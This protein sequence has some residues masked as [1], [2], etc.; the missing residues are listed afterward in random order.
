MIFHP[1]ATPTP[2]A[3]SFHSPSSAG[4]KSVRSGTRPQRLV[5][6]EVVRVM[7]KDEIVPVLPPRRSRSW[8]GLRRRRCRTNCRRQSS[9]GSNVA[10]I[11]VHPSDKAVGERPGTGENANVMMLGVVWPTATMSLFAS[12][13]MSLR[14][15]KLS[16]FRSSVDVTDGAEGG[17][18]FTV[19]READ[20]EEVA[21]VLPPMTIRWRLRLRR[22]S[23]RP[24]PRPHRLRRRACSCRCHR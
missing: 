6:N 4:V 21:V 17:V 8:R 23:A 22:G 19:S 9:E 2:R 24:R 20:H 13:A 10:A 1:T 14:T 7:S 11:G 15:S 16:S 5:E 18:E 12:T 3:T